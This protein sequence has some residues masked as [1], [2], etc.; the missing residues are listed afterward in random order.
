MMRYEWG[1]LLLVIVMGGTCFYTMRRG[2]SDR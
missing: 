1:E 2:L